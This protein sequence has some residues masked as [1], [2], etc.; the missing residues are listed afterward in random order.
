LTKIIH[1]ADTHLGYRQYNSEIRKQDFFD[2]FEHVIDEAINEEVDAVIHAGDLFDMRN[3]PLPDVIRTI[4]ILQKLN[5][6]D[7]PFLGIVGN[8][9]SKQDNQWLDLYEK[10]GIAIRLST[11]PYYINDVAIYGIDYIPKTKVDDHAF[12]DIEPP[13]EDTNHTILAMHQLAAHVPY[14][15]FNCKSIIDALPFRLDAFV[16]GDYHKY[17]FTRIEDVQVTYSGS[18]ERHASNE[19]EHRTYNLIETSDEGLDFT[20][21]HIPTRDFVYIDIELNESVED[22]QSYALE[23]IRERKSDINDSV[24]IMNI[25][26]NSDGTLS[27]ADIDEYILDLG[28]VV[29]RIND[30]RIMNEYGFTDADENIIFLEPD[31]AVNRKLAEINLTTGGETIDRII[32]NPSILKSKVDPEVELQI[33]KHVKEIDFSIPIPKPKRTLD[34]TEVENY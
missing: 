4:N 12:S 5:D 34:I 18:T 25:D 24:V 8:H 2:S 19:S 22:I 26:G 28:A 14:G 1:T 27:Y 33:N 20:R 6:N 10:M 15:K 16:L 30:K 3:P 21:K 9:E 29:S 31:E 7:I 32:R 13:K 23:R 17:T 11:Y